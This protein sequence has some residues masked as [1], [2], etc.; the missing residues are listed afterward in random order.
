MKDATKYF[1]SDVFVPL[2]YLYG[3]QANQV[4]HTMMGFAGAMLFTFAV[5]ELGWS[6][7][8]ALLFLVIPI[9]K[10]TTDYLVDINSVSGTFAISK[11][12]KKELFFD[13]VTDC[14]FWSAGA[15]MAV[16]FYFAANSGSAMVY[17]VLIL[18]GLYVSIGANKLYRNNKSHLNRFDRSGLP[19][20]IRLPQLRCRFESHDQAVATIHRFMTA[21]L[22]GHLVLAGPARSGKTGL[23]CAIGT[24]L[25]IQN[26]AVYYRT[27]EKLREDLL[28]WK[29]NGPG[30]DQLQKLEG[31]E[32]VICDDAL[33]PYTTD[34]EK[35]LREALGQKRILWVLARRNE[36]IAQWEQWLK[37]VFHL[38]AVPV[39][40]I[41]SPPSS[42]AESNPIRQPFISHLLSWLTLGAAVLSFLVVFC[43]LIF[44]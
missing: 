3:W 31:A 7:R 20:H 6:H 17:V 14:F 36:T 28:Q 16:F 15:V 25:T 35:N 1:G 13:G 30:G 18:V 23:C 26:K 41:V 37:S 5:V 19:M 34:L 27:S 24:H 2:T 33:D 29:Q 42:A 38:D 40:T 22:P 9:L 44:M 8:W 4:A 43:V 11:Q 32:F 12:L 21:Q 39:V 10:D